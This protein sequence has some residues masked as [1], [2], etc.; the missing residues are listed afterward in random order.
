MLFW[1]IP[2]GIRSEFIGD[3]LNGAVDTIDWPGIGHLY[4]QKWNAIF[5]TIGE[6]AR[7]FKWSD[8]GKIL[9]LV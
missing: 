6:S 5:T 8:F 9:R 2:D 3:G 4:A 1:T 7:T